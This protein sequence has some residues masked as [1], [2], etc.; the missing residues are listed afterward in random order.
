MDIK[1]LIIGVMILIGS[2]FGYAEPE[3]DPVS[4]AA[5]M[6]ERITFFEQAPEETEEFTEPEHEFLGT[7]L[8]LELEAYTEEVAEAYGLDPAV[9]YAVM[10]TESRF[11]ADAVGDNGESLGLMQIKAKWHQERM[12]R[13]GVTDLLEPQQNILVGCDFLAELL[14]EYGDMYTAL[15][16][17]RYGD[18]VITGEDYAAIVLELSDSYR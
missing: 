10:Y 8:S 13:L 16:V 9:V 6:N 14:A 5:D 18:T 12:A 1:A 4:M 3:H 7:G 2:T 15:T 11:Q 17:Y